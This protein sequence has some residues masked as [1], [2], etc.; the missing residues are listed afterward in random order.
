[1]DHSNRVLRL[2]AVL[3]LVGI[4]RSSLYALIGAGD[5]PRP[6]KLG[7]RAVGWRAETVDAWISR[8]EA[9]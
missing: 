2:P 7:K 5:F 1:M 3:E 4:S 8:R 6:L 9:A